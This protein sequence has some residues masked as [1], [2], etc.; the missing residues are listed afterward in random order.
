MSQPFLGQIT[1]YPYNFAPRGW[2]VCAGQVLPI[3]QNTALFSLLGTQFGGNGTSNFQLP[4]LQGNVPVGQ[5]QQ[6]GGDFYNMGDTGGET[7]VTITTSNVPP[8]SH[9]FNSTSQTATAAAPATAGG[10][11]SATL[12][13]ATAP[14]RRIGPATAALGTSATLGAAA[15]AVFTTRRIRTAAATL[16]TATAGR[17]SAPSASAALRPAA[18]GR[19]AT[20]ASFFL[21]EKVVAQGASHS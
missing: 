10:A 14:L 1:L 20:A 11:A 15:T 6:P 2:A 7:D 3:S 13:A 19:S 17:A 4:N 21:A 9:T 16:G 5:G 18:T 8:H 12:V